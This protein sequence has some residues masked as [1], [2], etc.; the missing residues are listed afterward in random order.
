MKN[1]DY[2]YKIGAKL[3]GF[4]PILLALLVFGGVSIALYISGNAAYFLTGGLTALVIV[5]LIVSAY[6]SIFNKM[7]LYENGFYYQT[8]PGNGRHYEYAE[9]KEAWGSAEDGGS[10]NYC[11]FKTMDGQTFKFPFLNY[12]YDGVDYFLT[13]INGEE[14]EVDDED[15]Y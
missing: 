4:F 11:C 7:L 3:Q 8:R 2:K 14:S 5:L 13:R 1:E 6:R 15:E 10:Y 9:I 12:D